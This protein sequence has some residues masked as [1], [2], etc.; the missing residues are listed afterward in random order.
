L[1]YFDWYIAKRLNSRY[2]LLILDSYK[3]YYSIAFKR[4]YK[5][6]KIIIFYISP[7]LSY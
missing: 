6:N 7:Y 1:K 3:S 5:E 4:Y 2:Y